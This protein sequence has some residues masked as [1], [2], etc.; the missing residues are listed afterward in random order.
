MLIEAVP[1]T[2]PHDD[3]CA[4][5]QGHAV[6]VYVGRTVVGV[7]LREKFFPQVKGPAMVLWQLPRKR[8]R[9][10]DDDLVFNGERYST[11]RARWIAVAFGALSTEADPAAVLVPLVEKYRWRG[12]SRPKPS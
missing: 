3:L 4:L 10:H 9:L 8:R 12:R 7:L 6:V 5:E 11:T 1:F 2:M